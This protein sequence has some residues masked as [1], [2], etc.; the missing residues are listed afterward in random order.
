MRILY[1]M[2]GIAGQGGVLFVTVLLGLEWET[3]RTF[4]I[5]LI[6]AGAGLD[7]IVVLALVV[8]HGPALLLLLVAVPVLSGGLTFAMSAWGE[9]I[10]YS[11]P[12]CTSRDRMADTAALASIR[13]HAPRKWLRT[14]TSSLR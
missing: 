6:Q 9:E 12:A 5:A 10:E 11:L 1:G 13:R 14:P 4:D 2:A 7:V 8:R 3:A